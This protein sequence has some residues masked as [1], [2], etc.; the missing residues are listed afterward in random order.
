MILAAIA[1]AIWVGILLAPWRAWSTDEQLNPMGE[2]PTYDLSDVT[3]LIPARD[4][5]AVIGTTVAALK[6]QGKGMRIVVIDDQSSDGTA[7]VARAAGAEV[8]RGGPLGEGWV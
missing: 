8:I 7:D 5:A 1:A 6:V 2:L 4:E 3:A